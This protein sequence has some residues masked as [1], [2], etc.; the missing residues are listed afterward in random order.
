MKAR[1]F[2]PQELFKEL[3]IALQNRE[4]L[5]KLQAITINQF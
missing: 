4:V 5:N 1:Q 2:S 3:I